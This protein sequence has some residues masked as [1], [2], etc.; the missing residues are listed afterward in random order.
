MG[1]KFSL[2]IRFTVAA[3]ALPVVR[4]FQRPGVLLGLLKER[5]PGGVEVNSVEMTEEKS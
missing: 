2:V 5:A 4:S 3:W 1:V